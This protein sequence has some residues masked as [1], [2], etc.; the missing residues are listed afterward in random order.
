MRKVF[1]VFCAT[2]ATTTV[3]A[4]DL[5][6]KV[7]GA[8]FLVGDGDVVFPKT[9]VCYPGATIGSPRF[10][11]S[12]TLMTW[13][14]TG[15]FRPV[16]VKIAVEETPNNAYYNCSYLSSKGSDS[17]AQELGFPADEVNKGSAESV[18]SEA[19]CSWR[20]GA[21]PI[22]DKTKTFTARGKV[23]IYG[24]ETKIVNGQVVD[25]PVSAADGFDLIYTP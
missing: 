24:I 5:S 6:V 23:A 12:K 16:M 4:D 1:F 3:F 11:I 18:S 8:A 2:L 22:K 14:G 15:T 25:R 21:F 7:S 19:I 17:I 13:T 9:D 20:C 10:A